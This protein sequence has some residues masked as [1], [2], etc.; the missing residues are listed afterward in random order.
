MPEWNNFQQ[1]YKF[2][3][4]DPALDPSAP[5]YHAWEGPAAAQPVSNYYEGKIDNGHCL[6]GGDN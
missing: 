5:T 4:P 3:V 6:T 1:V 2:T